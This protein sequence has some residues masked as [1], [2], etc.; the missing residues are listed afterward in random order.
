MTT[1]FPD[2]PPE[3]TTL[4]PSE[5]GSL[6]PAI[7]AAER[8]REF[9]S[10]FG[11]GKVDLSGWGGEPHPPLYARDLES[12]CRAT[13]VLRDLLAELGVLEVRG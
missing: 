4:E 11:D 1:D 13:V 3:V 2:Q 10:W 8:V 5:T 7:A 12:V 9:V 6:P